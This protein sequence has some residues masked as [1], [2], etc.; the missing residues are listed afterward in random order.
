LLAALDHAPGGSEV[1][2]IGGADVCSYLDLMHEYADR[3]G[4][5]RH[6]VP[7]PVLTPR[8]SSLWLHLVTPVYAGIGREL[9]DSLRNETVVNDPRALEV[10]PVRPRTSAWAVA[11]AL[12]NEDNE[13][14][15]TRW[16]D[17]ASAPGPGYGGSRYGSRLVDSRTVSLP[18]PPAAAFAPIQRIGGDTG[19][20]VGNEL[21]ELRGALDVLVGGPG[22]RRGRRDPVGLRVGDT[23]DFWR[24]ERFEQDRL[25][26]LAAE[27]KVPG[28]AWLQFE[29]DA[30][31]SGGSTIRQT[32]IFDPTGVF[33]L[34]YWYSLWPI[35]DYI[36]G[37]ML[38]RIATASATG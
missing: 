29:V 16:S 14:A 23:I 24:V 10:F 32:A 19:W 8:L 5:R 9:V 38:Q 6:M 31:D 3:R 12:A 22:L 33:G 27:M 1:F 30:D 36:F 34:A 7:V 35:H 25:L 37:G 17:E 15:E 2:E 26:R 18:R 11:R 21:W 4:L 28:R 20:Y 13:I